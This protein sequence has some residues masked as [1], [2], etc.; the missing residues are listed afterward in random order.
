[1]TFFADEWAFIADRSL[2]DTATWWQPH[3]EHWVT[4]P[5]LLYRGLVETVG[6]GSYVPYSIA[7]IGLHLVVAGF[8]YVLL[9]RE[10]GSWPAFMGS[11]VILLLGSGFENLFWGFQITFLGSVVLGLAAL[12]LIDG[13]AS[14]RRAGAIAVL[15]L[16]SFACSGV[17]AVMGVAVGGEMLLRPRWRHLI[18]LLV[19]PF[20]GYLLWL[21]L[22]GR[23]GMATFGDPFDAASVSLVPATVVR[24]L[25]NGVG[26]LVGLPGLETLILIPAGALVAWLIWHS[27]RPPVR[28]VALLAAVVALYVLTGLTRSGLFEGIVRYTRY[29]YVAAVLM[30]VAI[31]SLIDRVAL[32]RTRIGRITSFTVVGT[33]LSFALVTNV[34][35][36]V[37][38]RELFLQR[39][40]MTRALV[41]VTLDPDRPRGFDDRSPVLIPS[42]AD[43]RWI[44]AKYGDPR[45]DAV[46]PGSVREIPPEILLEARRRLVD[47]PPA[48]TV[49]P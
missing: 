3:N 14:V 31:G 21:V 1:M 49:A 9:E 30:M 29:T 40:D 16:A 35:L 20:G 10:C 26:A 45:S 27:H 23:A 24:G 44:V 48:T 46:V 38:G 17:G 4:L 2:S 8:V 7:V 43:V 39:A 18:G 12:S 25:A 42:P 22:A 15:L 37:L 11:L 19:I 32:P 34:G 47:G 13:G 5:M 28:F 33:W 36:L 6:I 41:T